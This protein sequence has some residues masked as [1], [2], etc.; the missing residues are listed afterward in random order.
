MEEEVM[1]Y[2]IVNRPCMREQQWKT[3][4]KNC[5]QYVKVI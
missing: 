2:V 3:H 4:S 1:I 5:Y